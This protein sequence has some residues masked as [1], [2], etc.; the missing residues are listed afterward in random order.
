MS[1]CFYC[2]RNQNF[3]KKKVKKKILK[4]T[5]LWNCSRERKKSLSKGVELGG[6]GRLEG[7]GGVTVDGWLGIEQNLIPF[8][9]RGFNPLEIFILAA[10]KIPE[11]KT[12]R[13]ASVLKETHKSIVLQRPISMAADDPGKLDGED[14][15]CFRSPLF[16]YDPK[17]LSKF[18]FHYIFF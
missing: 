6:V 10:S 8:S 11:C 3:L 9:A 14:G 5:V 13:L 17:F 15:T 12:P 16:L 2:S 7:G 18:S 4:K 1:R